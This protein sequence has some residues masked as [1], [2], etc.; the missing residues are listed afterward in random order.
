MNTTLKRILTPVILL[1]TG[2]LNL[3][4]L[5]LPYAAPYLSANLENVSYSYS[6]Y[7]M[8]NFGEGS[9]SQMLTE[10]I[11]LSTKSANGTFLLVFLGLVIISS[12][13]LSVAMI[14]LGTIGL[15]RGTARVNL[16]GKLKYALV[17]KFYSIA[18]LA[19]FI[20]AAAEF[21][22]LMLVCLINIHVIDIYDYVITYGLSPN[23][24]PFLILLFGSA[25]WI[26]SLIFEKRFAAAANAKL[27]VYTCTGC[28]ASASANDRFC[29]QCGGAVIASE[30]VVDPSAPAFDEDADVKDFKYS[31][32]PAFFVGAY[33]KTCDFLEKK[34]IS[35]KI[36]IVAAAALALLI[37]LI[38]ILICIPWSKSPAYIVP[39][40]DLSCVYNSD[41]DETVIISN[42]V[43]TD[44]TIDGR[45]S[46]AQ[47]SLSGETLT[48]VDDDGALNVYT[49]K[50]LT[51]V[52]ENVK[53]YRLAANGGA[54]AYVNE[55]DELIL[56]TV[57]KQ[58]RRR[59]SDELNDLQVYQ[60]SPDGGTVAY[61]EGDTTDYTMYV[62][63]GEPKKIEK[64]ALP[65]AVSKKGKLIYYYN[66][67]KSAVY[68]VEG[69][70]DPVK[71]LNTEAFTAAY[72]YMVF[73]ADNT[74]VLFSADNGWYIS[75]KGD[76]KV[77]VSKGIDAINFGGSFAMGSAVNYFANVRI[78]SLETFKNVVFLDISG[79]LH[80]I[81][82]KFEAVKIAEDVRGFSVDQSGETLYYRTYDNEL[83]RGEVGKK[84][85][86]KLAEDVTEFVIV[87]DGSACY[88]INEDDSLMYVRKA[89][90]SKKIADDVEEYVM[91][92]DGYL[93]FVTDPSVITGAGTLYSSNRGREKDLIAE[94]VS[95]VWAT[96]AGTYYSAIADTE[97]GLELWGA[98]SKVKFTKILDDFD[99]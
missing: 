27:V 69:K 8:L 80:Y 37:I 87:P 7:E 53:S 22:I 43:K 76:E 41:D 3:I 46:N 64:N 39:E 60:I 99:A 28:G 61:V 34:N 12:I 49:G 51:K 72:S 63:S 31:M 40:R 90:R 81:N 35:P 9:I 33:K 59:I 94:D 16:V 56:Y 82:K 10:L 13:I 68:V 44:T 4:F 15:V 88:Y 19:F 89:N 42:G 38:I 96:A 45:V 2:L 1:G 73:N 91:T 86:K 70:K 92:V 48:F 18:L 17:K 30:A 5:F 24:A 77:K 62:D 74:Q 85:F 97:G 36:V 71:L 98:K 75:E 6:G 65:I 21:S 58:D 54:I 55:D 57:K 23:V 25:G 32:I 11:E 47:V 83:Y 93:L 52:E 14:L 26:V 67:E 84:K 50:N 20:A 95:D 78:S 79:D 66:T 29:T